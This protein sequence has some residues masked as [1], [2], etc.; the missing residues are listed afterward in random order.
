MQQLKPKAAVVHRLLDN[1]LCDMQL[2]PKAHAQR[3]SFWERLCVKY[4][5]MC[6]MQ[7]VRN[8]QNAL[9]SCL[10]HRRSSSL[11]APSCSC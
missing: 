9:V 1:M 7:H 10:S 3:I 11:V 5:A 2:A 6:C 4:N 8:M